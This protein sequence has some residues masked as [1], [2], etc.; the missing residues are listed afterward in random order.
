MHL[1]TLFLT[2]KHVR[3]VISS[4]YFSWKQL[5]GSDLNRLLS[6]P[7]K[8]VLFPPEMVVYFHL[9]NCL[10]FYTLFLPLFPP[11]LLYY[12]SLDPT[13]SKTNKQPPRKINSPKSCL[14]MEIHLLSC[15]K[16]LVVDSLD[17]WCGFPSIRY[18]DSLFCSLPILPMLPPGPREF[19]SLQPPC[20]HSN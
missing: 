9:G 7:D 12:F 16:Y 13:V 10:C 4:R 15:K 11:S 2:I 17:W 6:R 18:S 14:N 19:L 1:S 5:S 20:F 3:W 8:H